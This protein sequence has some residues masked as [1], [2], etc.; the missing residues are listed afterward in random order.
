MGFSRQKEI[1]DLD[2][3]PVAYAFAL[4]GKALPSNEDVCVYRSELLDSFDLM[5]L[6]LEI[7]LV[8]GRRLDLADLMTGEITL[9]RLRSAVDQVV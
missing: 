4:L 7:E 2:S 6:L 5:Q 1:L 8:T 9:R 3:D